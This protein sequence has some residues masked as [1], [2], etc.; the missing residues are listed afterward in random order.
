MDLREL[1]YFVLQTALRDYSAPAHPQHSILL[2]KVEVFHVSTL[3]STVSALALP[4]LI[5][6]NLHIQ[7]LKRNDANAVLSTI[8]QGQEGMWVP[9]QLTINS[10]AH[11]KYILAALKQLP[12]LE[13]L[14]LIVQDA[15]AKKFWDA[16]IPKKSVRGRHASP[17]ATSAATN[18]NVSDSAMAVDANTASSPSDGMAASTA[19][20]PSAPATVPA[21]AKPIT[22]GNTL[23]PGLHSLGLNYSAFT[24]GKPEE[25]Q[26]LLPKIEELRDARSRVNLPLERLSVV[27]DKQ[28]GEK[29][30]LGMTMCPK[31]LA[32]KKVSGG[33]G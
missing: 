32:L 24:T 7:A 18:G 4:K 21:E 9:R 17:P 31:C 1:K 13:N 12:G 15:P 25:V 6:L 27:W 16:L 10:P 26:K 20:T 14:N 2:P 33:K 3:H 8:F 30:Y 5:T 28:E 23:V 22:Y 11:D 29:F 19:S